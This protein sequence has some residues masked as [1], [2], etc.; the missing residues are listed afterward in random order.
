MRECI[1]LDSL[2]TDCRQLLQ[3]LVCAVQMRIVLRIVEEVESTCDDT[4]M[5]QRG[6]KTLRNSFHTTFS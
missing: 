5:L 1:T 2:L 6:F 4:D 3:L